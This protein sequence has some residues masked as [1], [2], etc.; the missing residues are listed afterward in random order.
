MLFDSLGKDGQEQ[1]TATVA[2]KSVD[3]LQSKE[4]TPGYIDS[5]FHA[6]PNLGRRQ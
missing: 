6:C 4:Y 3:F 1:G 5:T 2:D